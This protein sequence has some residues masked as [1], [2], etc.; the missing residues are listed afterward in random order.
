[1]VIQTDGLMGMLAY[2]H[3]D[4]RAYRHTDKYAYRHTGMD[5]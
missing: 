5:A 4:T 1:M 3:T 2:R